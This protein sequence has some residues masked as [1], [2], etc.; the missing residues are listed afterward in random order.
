MANN[1]FPKVGFQI[2]KNCWKCVVISPKISFKNKHYED[3]T[4][5]H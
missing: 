2:E 4:D 5:K 3:I 1:T